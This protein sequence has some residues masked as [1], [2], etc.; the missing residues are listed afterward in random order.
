LLFDCVPA[1]FSALLSFLQQQFVIH[2]ITVSSFPVLFFFL[3]SILR[4]ALNTIAKIFSKI[5][6]WNLVP[7]SDGIGIKVDMMDVKRMRCG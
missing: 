6:F 1:D 2:R 5:H 7:F 3:H 4:H